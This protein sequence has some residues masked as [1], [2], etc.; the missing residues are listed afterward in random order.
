MLVPYELKVFADYVAHACAQAEASTELTRTLI[1]RSLEQLEHSRKV[2]KIESPK[3][4][5]PKP[6]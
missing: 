4:W 5:H 6:K 3:V 2:L 1:A